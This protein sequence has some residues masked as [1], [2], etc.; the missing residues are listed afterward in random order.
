M[1]IRKEQKIS[2][3]FFITNGKLQI[4]DDDLTVRNEFYK[5]HI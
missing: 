4:F 5:G 1:I 2:G 3:L